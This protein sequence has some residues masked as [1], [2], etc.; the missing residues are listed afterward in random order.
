MD[1]IAPHLV[2]DAAHCSK[3]VPRCLSSVAI[4]GSAT[5]SSGPETRVSPVQL[6][7]PWRNFQESIRRFANRPKGAECGILGE[8]ASNARHHS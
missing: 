1:E 7:V 3:T 2:D 6:H 4:E 5:L 8:I